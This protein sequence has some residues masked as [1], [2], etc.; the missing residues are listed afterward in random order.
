[1]LPYIIAFL[2]GTGSWIGSYLMATKKSKQELKALE[3]SNKHE[4]E[5]LMTQHEIDIE[6]L[7]ENH[8]L[9]MDKENAEHKHKIE[10]IE[11]EHKNELTR[12]DHELE[13]S[14]M[15][16]AVGDLFANPEKISELLKVLN[17]PT[18]KG[19]LKK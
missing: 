8:I 19:Y 7:K 1:M 3:E 6:S 15:Y 16:K 10:I 18:F 13:S 5:K 17:N 4:I 12:K 14:A 11:L 2:T 9:E